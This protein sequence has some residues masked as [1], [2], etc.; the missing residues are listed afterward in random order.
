MGRK[1]SEVLKTLP[2]ERQTK[3]ETLAQKKIEEL[4]VRAQTLTDFRRAVGKT[5]LQVAESLGIK[6]HA[7]SQLEKRSD[8]YVS[9]LRKFLES[10]GM[11]LELSVITQQ[12]IKIELPNFHPWEQE[13]IPRVTKAKRVMT[14][15]IAVSVKKRRNAADQHA[16]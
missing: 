13:P 10:L 8:T 1:L 11:R 6:Q 15:K 4:I 12:G 3:I 16:R 7:V 9:T 14:K 5:Q 2:V